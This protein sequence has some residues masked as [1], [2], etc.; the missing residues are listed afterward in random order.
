MCPILPW[1]GDGALT[2]CD[3]SLP[4]PHTMYACVRVFGVRPGCFAPFI[5]PGNGCVIRLWRELVRFGI[6]SPSSS[7]DVGRLSP[8][9]GLDV[10]EGAIGESCANCT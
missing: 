2:H 10:N 9:R 6:M 8:E 3:G 1:A 5:A 4:T 7:R